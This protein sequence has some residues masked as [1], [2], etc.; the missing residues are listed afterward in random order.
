MYRRQMSTDEYYGVK[1]DS[2]KEGP[3][4]DHQLPEGKKS[5]KMQANNCI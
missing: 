1:E 3:Q 4:H 5:Q 2:K